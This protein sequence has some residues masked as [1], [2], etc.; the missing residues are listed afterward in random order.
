VLVSPGM[1]DCKQLKAYSPM[2]SLAMIPRILSSP[3]PVFGVVDNDLNWWEFLPFMHC[4]RR[5]MYVNAALDSDMAYMTQWGGRLKD[6]IH[7]T[8]LMRDMIKAAVKACGRPTAGLLN[9]LFDRTMT[10]SAEECKK[11]GLVD[12][13]VPLY[14]GIS[15][16]QLTRPSRPRADALKKRPATPKRPVAPKKRSDGKTSATK[17]AVAPKK[18]TGKTSAAKRPAGKSDAKRAGAKPAPKKSVTR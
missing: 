17:R 13:V 8:T 9:N 15:P 1:S 6:I 10:I 11:N 14:A 12:K 4:H 2:L 18:P 3:V 16:Q 5:Y 7:N